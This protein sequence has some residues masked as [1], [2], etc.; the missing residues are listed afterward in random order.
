MFEC[1]ESRR[2]MS[3]GVMV[4]QS[5]GALLVTGGGDGS[6]LRVSE[7]GG[8]N[9]IVEDNGV[10]IAAF[11][12]VTSIKIAGQAKTD[13]IFYDGVS[14]GA[15]ISGGGGN[16]QITVTD[17]GTAG[18]YAS[19][20]G[21]D[22][23]MIVLDANRTTIVGDGGGDSL[24]VSDAVDVSKEVYIYGMG[25]ADVINIS[26]GKNYI[27]AGGGQDLLVLHG[28]DG[29]DFQVT[30]INVESVVTGV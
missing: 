21:G 2:L 19:G 22:D 18:S 1:L 30:Y 9:G 4:S 13:R 6:T 27:D 14:I 20:D 11:T 17:A 3:S 26:G 23:E 24:Y 16:D 29:V 12:G 15:V 7:T 25:G 28:V 5:G 8:G 10:Q